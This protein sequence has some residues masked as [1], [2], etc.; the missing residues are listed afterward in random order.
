MKVVIN[1]CYGGFGLSIEALYKC[2]QENSPL[3]KKYK[4]GEKNITEDWDGFIK[5]Y[6][7]E[8]YNGY[9]SNGHYY[10][11]H[12]IDETLY[13]FDK[14]EWK[15]NEPELVALVE[16]MGEAANGTYAKLKVVEI[17]DDVEY[18]IHDYDGM[19]TIH[20]KHRSWC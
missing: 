13:T 3:V 1:K 14:H 4:Y 20:E 19:E 9:L 2:V 8:D 11:Y 7:K 18:T 15:R 5:K 17:P 10:L 16:E 6:L 12:P